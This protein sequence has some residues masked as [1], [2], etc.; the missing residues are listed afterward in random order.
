MLLKLLAAAALL[1]SGPLAATAMAAPP[2]RE[3][4]LQ[5][6]NRDVFE[7]VGASLRNP[8]RDTLV[9]AVLLNRVG[10]RL[11]RPDGRPLTWGGWSAATAT[12]AVRTVGRRTEA[13]IRLGG[14][15]PGGLYSVFLGTLGPDSEHMR[16]LLILQKR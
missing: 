15:V 8:D 16:Q 5:S 10:V 4:A 14:V 12:S 13:R 7:I 6:F 3:D 11:E 1:L 2:D 9:D